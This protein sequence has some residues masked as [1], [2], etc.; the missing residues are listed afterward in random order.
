MSAKGPWT[1]VSLEDASVLFIR[2]APRAGAFEGAPN[3][4]RRTVQMSY[5]LAA[6]AYTMEPESWI[7][8][9]W[10]D[11][12]MLVNRSLTTGALLNSG[13][14][15]LND[16][17]RATLQTLAKLKMSGLNP[18]GQILGLRNQPPEETASLKAIVMLKP[19]DDLMTVAIGFMGT[20]KQLG[21]WMPNLRMD[22]QDGLHLGFLQLAQEFNGFIDQIEFPFAAGELG[23]QKLTLREIIG[24]MREPGSRFRL[25]ISGHSQGAAVMQVFID[26]LLRQGVRPEYL[27]GYG[28]ASPTVAHPGW[29]L[30]PDGYPITQVMNADDLVPRTGAWLHFGECLMFAPLDADRRRMYGAAVDEPCS[31][32][33]LRLLSRA[34]TAPETILQGMAILRVLRKQSEMTLRRVF[35]EADQRVLPEWLSSV[36][37]WLSS[38]GEGSVLKLLDSLI[39]RLTQGYAAVSGR[40]VSQDAQEMAVKAWESLLVKYGL[41]SWTRALRVTAMFPHR[42]YRSAPGEIASYRYIVT[43][44]WDRVKRQPAFSPRM[45]VMTVQAARTGHQA[46]T[47]YPSWSNGRTFRQAVRPVM[48]TDALPAVH[49]E[50]PDEAGEP[51]AASAGP[52]SAPV[53][54]KVTSG[55]RQLSRYASAFRLLTAS[56]GSRRGK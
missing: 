24:M 20:G 27:C 1:G 50:T 17:T 22:A 16:L 19:Q 28:F 43:Q 52:A 38:L 25:W 45:N 31:R 10:R 48:M 13:A 18:V 12:S 3:H 30:P 39:D 42:L 6:A 46:R 7:Q 35:G 54:R 29:P 15:P 21:D 32:E 36:P 53:I 5:E 23:R 47:M 34:Q 8:G 9:G 2:T 55:I 4:A 11:F 37:E 41:S 40:E 51:A 14:S 44:G 49:G 26:Q 33:A 56:R